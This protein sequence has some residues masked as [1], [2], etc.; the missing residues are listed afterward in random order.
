MVNLQFSFALALFLGTLLTG[1]APVA[2]AA[3]NDVPITFVGN[4]VVPQASNGDTRV[5]YQN[6]DN[7]IGELAVTGPFISGHLE[8]SDVLPG[9]PI[10]AAVLG[11][12]WAE[13]HVFFVS[14]AHVLSEWIYSGSATAGAWRG[15]PS[16]SDCIT[17]N[18]YIVQPG[19]QVLY[20]TA[21]NSPSSPA[22]LR[23][24]FV[25]SG[26]PNTLSEAS[27]TTARGW[28]LAQL[29]T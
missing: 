11:D 26:A 7:S 16:C 19:S 8:N 4:I 29:S 24:A 6:A 9:T 1:A 15:G 14:P 13:L 12:N 18:G 22:L 21:N 23:V 25:S 2:P 17:V 10:A 3:D 28:Q 20:A 27:F 5:Y